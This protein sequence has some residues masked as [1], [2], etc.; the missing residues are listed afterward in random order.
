MTA[1]PADLVSATS[2]Y[3][4]FSSSSRIGAALALAGVL[5][6]AGCSTVQTIDTIAVDR[7]QGSDENIASLSS[8][9]QSSPQNPEGYNVRGSADGRAGEFKRAREEFNRA[10]QINPQFYQAYA[11]R[12]L[13]YR[14]MGKPVE[15]A[16]DYT[17]AL[18]INPNYDV[19]FIGRGNISRQAGRN[20]EAFNDFSRAIQLDTTDGRA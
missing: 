6:L 12:A 5:T 20:D 1:K 11:N 17:R 7:A 18:Q 13:V 19:A 10:I 15:A 14:N 3:L 9:I 2:G 16:N 4:G 8:V